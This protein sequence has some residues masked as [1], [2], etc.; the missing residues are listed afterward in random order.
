MTVPALRRT[1]AALCVLALLLAAGWHTFLRPSPHRTL[2][3]DFA[4]VDGIFPGSRVA[5]LGVPVGT[6]E[7]VRPRGT[8]VRVTMSLPADVRLPEQVNAYVMSPAIV[9]D[10]FI[11]LG[12]AYTEGPQLADPAVIP[13]ERTHA[14]I[15]WEELTGSLDELLTA[16]GPR[17][18]NRDGG[19]G[20]L[21]RDAARML[22]PNG[23]RFRAA[24]TEIAQASEIVTG[25]SS[26]I[27]AVMDNVDTLV[28][29]LVN[30]RAA[31]DSLITSLSG[32]TGEFNARQDTVADT[33]GKLSSTLG[34][35]KALLDEHGGQ[36]TGDL[37]QLAGLSAT[38]VRHQ[39][40]LAE[41]LDTLPL[42]LQNFD[43]AITDERLRIR[44]DVSTNLSQLP[45]TA[46]LCERFPI[47]LC[48]GAGVVNPVPIPPNIPEVLDPGGG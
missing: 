13:V 38:M 41:T 20:A 10:R 35:V 26:D 15:K 46:A 14:P 21:L 3:A 1:I 2:A 48:S 12:P 7:S 5:I 45:T 22:G 47:P 24:I 8:A 19:L 6:V 11:E 43:R 34:Q 17:G 4:T 29:L 40:Q 37:R 32:L 18:L 9:S 42:A 39:G 28:T 25:S 30:N 36:L 27:G 23:D 31:I 33:I 16:L 44:L